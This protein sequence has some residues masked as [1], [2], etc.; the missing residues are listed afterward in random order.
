MF[1]PTDNRLLSDEVFESILEAIESGLL[2][3]GDRVFEQKIAE[4]MGISRAPVREAIKKLSVQ[5][6]VTVVPRKGAH[7]APITVEDVQ[8][9][10]L[11][12]SYLEGLS[13]RLA[14][15]NL[16]ETD[17][18]LL[19]HYSDEMGKAIQLNEVTAFIKNDQQFHSLVIER[20]ENRP[21]TDLLS[22]IKAQTRLY[23]AMSKWSLF[24]QSGLSKESNVHDGI[25]QAFHSKDADLAEVR[26]RVHIIASGDMLASQLQLSSQERETNTE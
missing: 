17:L 19:R 8:E 7:I 2:K 12:R 11:V 26:M 14:V 4:Q 9:L 20:A 15:S 5:G 18:V 13:A 16:E 23:M 6:I 24:D 25:L 3:S 1:R 21:L 10:Y 22:G